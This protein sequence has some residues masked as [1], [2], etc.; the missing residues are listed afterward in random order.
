[1]INTSLIELLKLAQGDRSQNQFALHCGV[2]SATLSHIMQGKHTPSPQFL[3]K[4]AD[5]A[6]N[7]VTYDELLDASIAPYRS[8]PSSFALSA[9]E[10]EVLFLFDGLSP[11]RKEDLKIYLRA[12]SGAGAEESLKLKNS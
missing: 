9:E 2:S 6:Y 10:R 8:G 3:K 12:L 7:G 1:M 5:R 4:I 11:S